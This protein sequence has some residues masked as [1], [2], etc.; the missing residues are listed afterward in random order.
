MDVL[1]PHTPWTRVRTVVNWVNLSTPIGLLLARAGGAQVRRRG[2]GTWV[3]GG[4]RWGFPRAGAFTVG[5]VVL[6]TRSVEELLGREEL[7]RHEDRP[8]SQYAWCLG[9]FLLVPYLAA[10]GLSWALA[11]DHSSYNPFERLAGLADGGYP[12]PQTRRSRGPRGRD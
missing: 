12:A 11:G 2:R 4:Y 1:L 3:A 8:C 6:S 7:L 9:P 5:S 10:A